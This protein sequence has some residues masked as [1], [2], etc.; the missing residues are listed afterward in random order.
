MDNPIFIVGL[1]RSGSTLWAKIL[2]KNKNILRFRE[3]FFLRPWGKD[4]R[5]F[6][7]K[8]VGDLSIENNITK[9]IELIFSGE[10]I[11]G[12]NG[13][14]WEDMGKINDNDLKDKIH[15]KILNSDKSLENIFKIIIEE[16]TKFKGY[17]RCFVKF[18][19]Y[20][21]YIPKLLEWYPQCK[22]IHITRDP[23]AIAIS[24]TNDPGGTQK[25]IKKYS[26]IN[27]I[28]YFIKKIMIFFVIFQYIWDSKVHNKCKKFQN[29]ALF[30]YEDLLNNPEKTILE[31]CEF[32]KIK[33]NK[34]MLYPDEG[35]ESSL[36]GKKRKG[37]DK[38]AAF[39]WKNV[40]SPLE[41]KIVTFFTKN[42]MKRFGYDPIYHPIFWD[43]L[44]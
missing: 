35:E 34:R 17:K 8:K 30:R 23:R 40:I 15:N 16:T 44:D 13:T 32:S 41:K 4:F 33:F 7:R 28:S 19:V 24:K 6:Y 39:R 14:F 43:D 38:K 10:K 26:Q 2:E 27:H 18:P 1:P 29:Y 37:F 36:T 11:A 9:M 31:L 21:S 5:Y 42:S 3:M 12:I 25:L 22:V 20:F